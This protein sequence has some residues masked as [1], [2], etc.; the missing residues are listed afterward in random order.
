[1]RATTLCVPSSL[2]VIWLGCALALLGVACASTS[3]NAKTGMAQQAAYSEEAPAAPP[4]E[5]S[6]AS[7][8]AAPA[9]T[10]TP[11]T[12]SMTG[13]PP[14]FRDVPTKMP[15]TSS[16]DREKRLASTAGVSSTVAAKQPSDAEEP[17]STKIT[18]APLLIYKADIVL[19]V[20][21]VNKGLDAVERIAREANGY[22]VMRH[23]NS[24]TVR[25][26]A[27]GFDSSLQAVLK[28]GDVLQRDLQV[29][30]VTAQMNDLT[31]RLKNAEAMRARL[32]Q[33]LKTANTTED[34]LKV[35]EQLGRVTGEI[36]SLKGKIRLMSELVS[37]STLTVA[38]RP[39]ATEKLDSKFKLPF[40]WLKDLG[41]SRLMN[42]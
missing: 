30:D 34:A 13:E 39:A 6:Y 35:E 2:L 27:A 28:L 11:Q 37:F 19:A 7:E 36:E 14:A 21:E 9:E 3:I 16:P 42:L 40:Q 5:S 33:L 32:E 18:R 1:V 12:R 22:L 4:D 10:S 17:A 24:I 41:L 8:R 23:D 38:F 29:D 15:A 25:V 26:P 20:F 31:T